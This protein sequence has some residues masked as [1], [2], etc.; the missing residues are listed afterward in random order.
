MRR[1]TVRAGVLLLGLSLGLTACAS[2]PVRDAAPTLAD[3]EPQPLALASEA[4]A[5]ADRASA[6]KAYRDFLA[7]QHTDP[8]LRAAALRRLADLNLD[9]GELER[10]ESELTTVDAHSA[11]AIELY[12]TLLA[13]YPDYPHNEA[14]LYQLARAYDTTGQ[15]RHALRTLDRI[16]ARYPR[17]RDI[18]EVQFRRGELLFSAR[19]YAEAEQAYS[20]VIARGPSSSFYVQSLYKCGW[21]LFKESQA[22]ASLPL[23]A[24]LLDHELLGDGGE[25]RALASLKRADR[26]LVEDSLR[27]MSITFSQESGPRSIAQF[28]DHYG[29]RPYEPLL[30]GE[31][32]KLYLAKQRYQDAASAYLAYVDRR[33]DADAAPALAA[34]AIGAY[35]KGGFSELVVKAKQLYVERYGFGSPFWADRNRAEQ[36]AVVAQLQQNLRDVATY[37]Q[38]VAQQSHAPADYATAAHWYREYL[39]SFPHA[40]DA[41]TVSYRLADSLFAEHRY[42]AAARAYEHTAYDYPPSAQSARAGYAAL[43]AYRRAAA[44][45]SGEPHDALERQAVDSAIRFAQTFPDHPDSAGVLT[46]AGE[47]LYAAGDLP[48]A[49][50]VADMLLARKSPASAAKRRIAWMIIAQAEYRQGQFEQAEPAFIAARALTGPDAKM[51]A[52]VTERLAATVYQEGAARRAAGDPEGAVTDFLRVEQLAPDSS[53]CATALYDAAAE[54]ITLKQWPRAIEVL[55][56]FRAR[57][58]HQTL[59]RNVTDKLAVAY[60]GANEP[61]QAALEF[62]KVA[63]ESAQPRALKSAALL[64]A[65]HLFRKAND[66]R[67]AVLALERFVA[68]YPTPLGPAEEARQRLADYAVAAGDP[69]RS[70]RWYRAIV[71]ADAAAGALRTARTHYLAAK[72]QLAL[73]APARDEFRSIRLRQPLIRTLA[74]K[75]R[76]MQ[77]ALTAYRLAAAY[78]YSDVTTA[79]TYEM[80]NLYQ[81]LAHDLLGSQRPPRLTGEALAEY[82][83][84]LEDQVFPFEEQAI[85]IYQINA[86]RTRQGIYDAWVRRSFAALAQLDPARYGKTELTANVV[87]TLN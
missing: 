18:D 19:R 10:M 52:E 51:R 48:R 5:P 8:A 26:E 77:R 80:A 34:R 36:P 24:R 37:Y 11:R 32:G 25:V 85:R 27:V 78:G 79:A 57:F 67:D 13:V 30:Y 47:A 70:E 84:L 35:A 21:S 15:P 6:M 50:Q 54:L 17:S 82:D 65:A 56:D 49:V 45:L 81:T 66:S 28:L 7:L 23:F 76:A 12:K 39:E 86:A 58:P 87:T 2:R 71:A 33:P 75:R 83:S 31:L 74:A 53:I 61:R 3:L 62:E 1:A 68:R 73:A 14:V 60:A 43:D 63:D 64:R 55:N 69:A 46:R 9:A 40:G 42:R 41:P 20:A 4:R 22:A 44:G 72:A 29:S 16:V 59:A 38:A